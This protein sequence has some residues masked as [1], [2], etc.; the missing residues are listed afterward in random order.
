MPVVPL[1]YRDN[2]SPLPYWM[3]PERWVD[4]RDQAKAEPLRPGERFSGQKLV[5]E[6]GLAK[7]HWSRRSGL[8]VSTKEA[9]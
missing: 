3:K 4:E 7:S 1:K 6:V 5:D 2:K 8:V 9:D